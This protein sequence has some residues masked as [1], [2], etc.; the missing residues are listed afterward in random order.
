MV[1]GVF[2]TQNAPNRSDEKR[3]HKTHPAKIL[4]VGCGALGGWSSMW[5]TADARSFFLSGGLFF[6]H[7]E[8]VI[9]LCSLLPPFSGWKSLAERSRQ[10]G[11]L[12]S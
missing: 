3:S 9:C 12:P 11:A 5:E 6:L 4:I 2:S 7:L 1:F 10:R 8:H